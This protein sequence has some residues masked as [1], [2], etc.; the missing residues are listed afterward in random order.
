MVELLVVIAIIAMLL[1]ILMP[2]LAKVRTLAQRLMCGTNIGGIGKAML[3][4]ASDD[5]YESYPIAGPGSTIWDI[6]PTGTNPD[7]KCSWDWKVK[8]PPASKDN[9]S[10]TTPVESTISACFYLLVKYA[11]V[12]PDQFICPGGDEK[13]FEMTMYSIP[14]NNTYGATLTELWDFGTADSKDWGTNFTRGRGHVGYSYQLPF[15]S[16]LSPAP[17]NRAF[18][19]YASSAPTSVIAAD[20]SPWWDARHYTDMGRD[21][22]AGNYKTAWDDTCVVKSDMAPVGGITYIAWQNSYNHQRDGQNV[23][24]A[25]QHVKFE[26]TACVGLDKDNIY[27]TWADDAAT[28]NA[29]IDCDRAKQKQLGKGEDYFP[30][31]SSS[32]VL[33]DCS[34]DVGDT[35]L[36]NDDN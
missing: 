28:V 29:L 25:D 18:P 7:G 5:K 17:F 16:A 32:N 6:G 19:I 8:A 4:Y 23:L 35:F 11:D 15:I 9:K 12:P 20:R 21:F 27:I 13:K 33:P 3:T 34:Q 22:W 10:T 1:A 2:A 26:K 31:H 36:V 14:S 30:D 24:Y